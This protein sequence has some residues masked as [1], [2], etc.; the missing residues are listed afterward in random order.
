MTLCALALAFSFGAFA[1]TVHAEEGTSPTPATIKARIEDR[2]NQERPNP[3]QKNAEA[4]KEM[5][6]QIQTIKQ[7][8]R[9]QMKLAQASSTEAR[10]MFKK[11]AKDMR[12]DIKKKMEVKQFETRKN[13]LVKELTR[14]LSNLAD[15]VTRIESRITKAESEGRNMTEPKA[16]LVTAIQK[17][18]KAKTEVAAFQALSASSTPSTTGST[19]P[20]VDLSKPRQIGD[21]AIKS[22]KEARDALQKVVVSIAHNMGLG[23]DGTATSTPKKGPKNPGTGTTTPPTTGTTTQPTATTTSTN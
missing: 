7:D 10:A 12:A 8:G 16:L 3:L 21:A 17:I 18:A 1:L 19:T 9:E 20:E 11:D 2:K 22:V 4:R 5:Q 15:I 23:K 14:A 13:A 6:G